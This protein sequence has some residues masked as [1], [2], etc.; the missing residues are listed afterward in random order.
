MSYIYQ[1][2]TDYKNYEGDGY[3]EGLDLWHSLYTNDGLKS[4]WKTTYTVWLNNEADLNG[5]STGIFRDCWIQDCLDHA[6][7]EGDLELIDRWFKPEPEEE[8]AE[9]KAELD[10]VEEALKYAGACAER[11]RME[12]LKEEMPVLAR[13]GSIVDCLASRETVRIQV[14]CDAFELDAGCAGRHLMP[15][16]LTEYCMAL[17][18]MLY[19]FSRAEREQAD[20]NGVLPFRP[21]RF[22]TC[23]KLRDTIGYY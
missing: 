9:L 17:E 23:K 8:E 18:K 16:D 1:V 21:S 15:E 6:Q 12:A 3:Q 22:R 20:R 13:C 4:T 10:A 19:R 11:R 5:I 7:N 2:L 14:A